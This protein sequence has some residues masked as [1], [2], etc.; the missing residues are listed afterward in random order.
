ML[1]KLINEC[2]FTL[3][4]VTEGPLLIKSGYATPHGSDMTP[5]LTYRNGQE[6]VYIPGT[7]LKGVFRSHIEK[8]IRSFNEEIVCLPYKKA[9][10]NLDEKDYLQVFCGNRFELRKKKGK[11][12]I[13]E[14]RQGAKYRIANQ[15]LDPENPEEMNPTVYKDSCPA[16]RLFGSTYFTGRISINDA[17]LSNLGERQRMTQFIETR[18]GVAIDRFTGGAAIES[19]ALFNLDVVQAGVT[20]ETKIYLRNFEIWQLGA[21]MLLI[22]DIEDGIIQIGSGKSRGLGKVKGKVESVTIQYLKPLVCNEL[23]KEIWGLGK[24][25]SQSE[26]EDY[27]TIENDLLNLG[28]EVPGISEG[29]RWKQVFKDDNEHKSLS[30]LIEKAIA[31]FV[32]HIQ[33]WPVPDRMKVQNLGLKKYGRDELQ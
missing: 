14:D 27:G 11:E 20:F 32:E 12:T 6:Q 9:D 33:N 5:V 25:M 28:I 31:A 24:F 7:S 10:R 2:L 3:Q 1:K 16:C 18:D 15:D 17:Y 22:K 29:I 13:I 19:G 8:V 21:L 23:K 4:L 26:S 30:M